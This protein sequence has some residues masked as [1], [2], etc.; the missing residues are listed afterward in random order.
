[1]YALSYLATAADVMGESRVLLCPYCFQ[2]MYGKTWWTQNSTLLLPPVPDNSAC[3]A[4]WL[5]SLF[6]NKFTEGEVT[7]NT[8]G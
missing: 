6:L 1:M 5:S 8:E 7:D 2:K 4:Q 3:D